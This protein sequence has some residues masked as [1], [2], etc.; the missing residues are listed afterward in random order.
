MG[1]KP[2]K[3]TTPRSEPLEGEP[4]ELPDP[5]SAQR[6]TELILRLLRGEVLDAVSRESQ[7]PAHELEAMGSRGDGV[8][9]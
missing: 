7:V 1:T 3:A 2:R 6:K 9:S 4:A 8:K 5:W